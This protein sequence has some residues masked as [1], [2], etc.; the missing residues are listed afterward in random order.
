VEEAAAVEQRLL[1]RLLTSRPA[2]LLRHPYP[3]DLESLVEPVESAL[4]KQS[5]QDG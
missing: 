5:G 3:V 2:H 4:W 1:D